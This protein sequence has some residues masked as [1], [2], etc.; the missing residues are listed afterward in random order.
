MIWSEIH[1]NKMYELLDPEFSDHYKK[2]KTCPA[3]GKERRLAI[4]QSSYQ[5]NQI[6]GF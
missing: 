4:N 6:Y 5:K 1:S 3:E 2:F